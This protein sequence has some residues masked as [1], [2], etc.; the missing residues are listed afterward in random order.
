MAYILIKN[1]SKNLSMQII[2]PSKDCE[3]E[4]LSI[5]SKHE[6]LRGL[7]YLSISCLSTLQ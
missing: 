1:I 7:I 5:S 6:C 2:I 4:E 3:L